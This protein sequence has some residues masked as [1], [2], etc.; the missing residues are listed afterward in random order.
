MLLF[1]CTNHKK[2]IN[3]T[4]IYEQVIGVE[5]GAKTT[6]KTR[7]KP[8]K[9]ILSLSLIIDTLKELKIFVQ[10]TVFPIIKI[11]LCSFTT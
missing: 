6:T 9:H 1:Y 7:G 11:H 2:N 3:T 8:I 4:Q 5:K 10:S